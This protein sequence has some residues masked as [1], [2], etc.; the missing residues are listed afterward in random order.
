MRLNT[1]QKETVVYS[2]TNKHHAHSVKHKYDMYMAAELPVEKE[3]GIFIQNTRTKLEKG[4]YTV[5]VEI[6]KTIDE[7]V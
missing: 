5:V 4:V 1:K 3:T 7:V 2:G 6:N